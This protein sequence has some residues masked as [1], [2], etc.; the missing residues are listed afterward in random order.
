MTQQEIDEG[1][2][3]PSIQRIR[4]VS[5]AVACAVVNEALRDGLTTTLTPKH[6]KE[7]IPELIA[8]K[9]YYPSYVPL[10]NPRN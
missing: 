2:T 4:D 3:F 8:R 10:I 1:K 7:G 6:L 5:H 9:M